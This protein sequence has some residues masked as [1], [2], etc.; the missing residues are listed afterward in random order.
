MS[1]KEKAKEEIKLLVEKYNRL[2]EAGKV[3]SYNEEMKL[4]ERTIHMKNT[5]EMNYNFK[6]CNVKISAHNK[7]WHAH[8]CDKC[9]DKMVGN[10]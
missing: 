1:N 9:F 8:L 5:E 10:D 7:D 3:K 2:V 4:K 6:Q